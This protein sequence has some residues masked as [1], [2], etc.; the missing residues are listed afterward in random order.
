MKKC[1]ANSSESLQDLV[2]ARSTYC[3]IKKP[4]IESGKEGIVCY[5]IN[6]NASCSQIYFLY[7]QLA[8]VNKIITI[9]LELSTES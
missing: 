7:E 9:N 1:K 5:G 8:Q 4:Y 3:S 6:F 2:L